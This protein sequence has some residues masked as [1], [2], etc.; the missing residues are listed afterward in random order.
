MKCNKCGANIRFD[1][2]KQGLLCDYC[3]N[4]EVIE[5]SEGK[6]DY[7]QDEMI[8]NEINEYKCLNC[9]AT[10]L[11]FDD[12][13]VTFCSYCKS[14]AIVKSKF[15]KENKPD[16]V[17]P[18]K[19]TRSECEEIYKKYINK[20][21]FAPDYLKEDTTISKFRG[22]YMPYAV[23]NLKKNGLQ[24]Y[25][26][27][28]FSHSTYNYDY[29]NIYTIRTDID[30]EY[31]NIAFDISSKFNDSFS[32]AIAPFN[33][34]DV[35][36]FNI[37]YLSGFYADSPD[38]IKTFYELEAM[39]IV[40]KLASDDLAR[41]TRIYGCWKPKM[42][43]DS[44][45]IKT[46]YYPV[47]FL[48]IE[49]KIGD[50]CYA[51]INGQT[52][53]VTAEIPID[54]KKFI[55]FTLLLAI[56]IFVLLNMFLTPT[57]TIITWFA[58]IMSFINLVLFKVQKRKIKEKE[59][60]A[61]DKGFGNFEDTSRKK[62]II[63][64]IER[65]ISLIVV[66]LILLMF[67]VAPG[68]EYYF[69]LTIMLKLCSLGCLVCIINFKSVF[70]ALK[71]FKERKKLKRE[72]K[73]KKEKFRIRNLIPYLSIIIPIIVLLFNPVED[74]YYY[75]ASFSTIAIAFWNIFN[76]VAQHNEL[77]TRK[78]SQLGKRGGDDDE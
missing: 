48:A 63:N 44:C 31:G 34:D 37:E 54:Y 49:N 13:A 10:L 38:V 67:S 50:I 60:R 73:I 23:Y 11:T 26:G 47:Y 59:D 43:F 74:I 20:F 9:G 76:L 71:E 17:I 77:S 40:E 56:P 1:P 6:I 18:F 28:K 14:S 57:P 3:G 62:Y 65:I 61:G 46:A 68:K 25:T 52:G 5:H 64:D 53:K 24:I 33:S 19:I 70:E 66:S 8:E 75:I 27:R 21:P 7:A 35:K 39:Q 58:L 2:K 41:I 69:P 55:K 51:I 12:T 36:P 45:D 15:E 32:K 78:P 22:I 4:F 30:A 16:L 72:R 42:S 29:Y